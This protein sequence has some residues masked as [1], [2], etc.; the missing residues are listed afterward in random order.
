MISRSTDSPGNQ[1]STSL[2][3][4][5]TPYT[6]SIFRA[7]SRAKPSPTSADRRLDLARF[8]LAWLQSQGSS[9]WLEPGICSANRRPRLNG[10]LCGVKFFQ[11]IIEPR[12]FH[13][14]LCPIGKVPSRDPTNLVLFFLVRQVG[15][16][17]ERVLFAACSPMTALPARPRKFSLHSRD[18]RAKV[19][20][21]PMTG[22]GNSSWT[23]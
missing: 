19:P 16:D 17:D 14:A 20:C 12:L 7:D 21:G 2:F 22:L 13:R 8:G 1:F 18:P 3:P 10:P 15:L 23:S 11:P 5:S 6:Y 9:N 4:C